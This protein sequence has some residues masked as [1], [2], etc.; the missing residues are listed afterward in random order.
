MLPRSVDVIIEDDLVDK[1]KPGDRI[2]VRGVYKCLPTGTT[3][4]NGIFRSILIAT[5]INIL[6]TEIE[7]KKV[8]AKDISKIKEIAKRKD[9]LELMTNSIAPSIFGHKYIK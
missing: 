8:E 5:S 6:A 3:T 4:M 7:G 2:E 1:V 9:L